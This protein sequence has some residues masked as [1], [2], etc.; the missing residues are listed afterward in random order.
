MLQLG[1][2][3]GGK[4]AEGGLPKT[5]AVHFSKSAKAVVVSSNIRSGFAALPS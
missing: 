1:F 5:A 2:A 4:R 3:G